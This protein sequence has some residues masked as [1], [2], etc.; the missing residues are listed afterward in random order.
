ML[1]VL[2]RNDSIYVTIG[3]EAYGIHELTSNTCV[4]SSAPRFLLIKRRRQRIALP[5]GAPRPHKPLG[6][7]IFTFSGSPTI[8]LL[9]AT[10][11]L[12]L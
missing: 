5:R 3:G 12:C 1:Q 9:V 10:K 6:I 2:G 7:S 11:S 8:S 4:R